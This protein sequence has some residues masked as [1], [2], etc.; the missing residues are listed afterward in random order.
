[1]QKAIINLKKINKKLAES[2][3]L[4]NINIDLFPGEIHVI[5]GENASGKS[6]IMRLIAGFYQPDSGNYFL[7]GEAVTVLNLA[8]AKRLG[9]LY[10]HQD[11]LLFENLTVAENLLFDDLPKTK[12]GRLH[13]MAMFSKAKKILEMYHIDIDCRVRVRT[14][15]YAQR[16]LIEAA[17]SLVKTWKV[18]ILDEPTAV[19]GDTERNIVFS[20][21]KSLKASGAGIFYVTHRLDEAIKVADRISVIRHG[22]V[23]KTE[24]IEDI[25]KDSL[26]RLMA[27]HMQLDRYPKPIQKRGKEVLKVKNL[28]SSYVLKNINFSLYK[29]EVLGI[30]G[31]VGSGRTRLAECLAGVHPPSGGQVFLHNRQVVF[32]NPSEALAQGISL[33]PEDRFD[34]VIL[35]RQNLMLNISLAALSRFSRWG[36]LNTGFIMEACN[37]YAQRFSIKPGNLT[38]F[39]D[40]YSGG[41]QQKVALARF[42]LLRSKIYILDEPTRGVDIATRVDIYNAIGDIVLKG[43]SVIL[44]SSDIEEILGISDRVLVLANGQIACDL[45]RDQVDEQKILEYSI[46]NN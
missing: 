11:P 28:Q 33:V 40:Y 34:N 25:N 16:F 10:Q 2:F 24:L 13:K 30:T 42:L 12:F 44:I 31:L 35:H 27:G 38:D 32:K 1:M 5:V 39:P 6:A 14:L 3:A 29:N 46:M 8:N 20:I 41:N 18:V 9:I 23:H 7:N 17:K 37:D 45:A 21:V 19:L 43:A 26:V 36:Y 4:K 22:T 15:G